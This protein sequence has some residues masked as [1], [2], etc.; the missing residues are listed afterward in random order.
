M[1]IKSPSKKQRDQAARR[2]WYRR[3][4][5][6]GAMLLTCGAPARAGDTNRPAMTPEQ[7]FEGGTNPYNNWVEF[8][9]GDLFTSGSAAQAQQRYQLS[10]DPFGG[11]SDLHLQKD[12]AKKTTLTLDGHA[13]FDQND[14]KLILGLQREE[15]GYVR[16]NINDFRTWYNGAG[17]YFPPTGIQYQLPNDALSLDR[18]EISVEA[19]LTL[20][21]LPKA[22]FKYTHSYRDGDKSSTIWGPL[23]PELTP[24]VRGVYP[25]IY[26]INEKVDSFALDVTH[27][28][29]TTDFGAGVRYETASLNDTRKETFWQGEPVQRDVTDKQGTSY[30]MLNVHAFSETWLKKNLFFSTGYMFAN[31]DDTFSGSRIY[32]DDFD[33]AYSPDPLNGLGYTSLHGGTHKQ[34]HVGNVN[35]MMT[36]I[37][38]L[39][40]VP[41]LRVQQDNWNANSSGTGT[42]GNDT[43]PFSGKSDGERLSVRERLDVRYTGMTN[44]V[45][46]G[47][48]EWTEG[49][50]NLN[51]NGGL[52]QVNAS[53]GPPPIQRRTDDTSWFQ[54]YFIGA[55]WYPYRRTSID[56]G[57]YY[58]L[59]EYDYNNTV[60]STPN[61]L[62]TG[63]VYPA[64]LVMQSFETYDGNVRLTLRPVKNV[65]LV[66]RYEYQL[67][68]INTKPDS[69]SG[70]GNVESSK[71][72]SHIIAQNATWTPWSRLCL[73]AGFNYV[74]SETR[75]P[76]SDYTQAVLDAQNNYWTVT[77]NSAVVL[78]DKT[79]LNLGYVYY[80]ADNYNNNSSVGVP[81]GAGAEQQ[82]VTATL[83]RRITRN[84]RLNLKYGYTHYNDWA[85]GGKNN[86]DAQVVYSSLQYRF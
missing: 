58:K 4:I 12:V 9:V 36:P 29:K 86:Y 55:R 57:G 60:D 67:S 6:A 56:V 17:G 79:D 80:Q 73:Q 50:G 11:I 82:S 34:E 26:S 48:G 3:C 2:A 21:N 27:H 19:G 66:S 75:T 85:S 30:D 51:E 15:F 63:N 84:L 23:H 28:I 65:A 22:V 37:K 71:M 32:G 38:N 25:S 77:F 41:S 76:A 44:W 78:D 35:L 5:M 46:Y 1:K 49:S 54:K 43:G 8:S 72:T 83:T 47:G 39:T 64:Y 53:P 7:M 45:Y 18:G 13:L 68:T 20:K 10:N 42:L 24:A 69:V 59:H 14:Y 52:S 16:F 62:S 31:L 61:I 74:W 81:L 70:L 40:I 33:V